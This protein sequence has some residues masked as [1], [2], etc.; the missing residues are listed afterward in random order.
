MRRYSTA[1]LRI[2]EHYGDSVRLAGSCRQDNAPH[3]MTEAILVVGDDD[4]P[5]ATRDIGP[6][7]AKVG[8]HWSDQPHGAAGYYLLFGPIPIVDLDAELQREARD[9]AAMRTLVEEYDA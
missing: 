8:A 5:E 6:Y 1:H 9:F 7:P 2:D 3:G 4:D